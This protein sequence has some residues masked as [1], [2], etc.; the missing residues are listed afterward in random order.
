MLCGVERVVVEGDVEVVVG[1]EDSVD[2]SSVAASRHSQMLRGGEV[3][4]VESGIKLKSM[5]LSLMSGQMSRG[6]AVGEGGGAETVGAVELEML[7]LYMSEQLTRG[8]AV[9][10]GGGVE[11][12]GAG[13]L[14]Y[15]LMMEGAVAY[16]EEIEGGVVVERVVQV[17][18]DGEG[19][20]GVEVEGVVQ[21][22]D[23]EIVFCKRRRLPDVEIFFA[24]VG[25]CLRLKV[26]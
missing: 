25:V 7:W 14:E 18:L 5:S 1:G 26:Q 20:G 3:A 19:E 24:D 9:G 17:A 23:V 4:E 12:A 8:V 11:T 16:G 21:V 6:V 2:T 22:T 15:I 13:E 10:E